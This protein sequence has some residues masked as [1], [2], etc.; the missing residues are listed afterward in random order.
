MTVR[1]LDPVKL[2]DFIGWIAGLGG[3]ATILLGISMIGRTALT[4]V[5]AT[6]VFASPEG[7]SSW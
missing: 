7:T 4:T 5:N 6:A 2:P 1:K 3:C